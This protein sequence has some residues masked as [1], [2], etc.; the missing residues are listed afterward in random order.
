MQLTMHSLFKVLMW[1]LYLLTVSNGA[2]PEG[3]V[4]D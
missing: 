1:V 4:F 3:Y 2:E